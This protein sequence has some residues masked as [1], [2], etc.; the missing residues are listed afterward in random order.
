M[1]VFEELNERHLGTCISL[2]NILE[3][4]SQRVHC[5]SSDLLASDDTIWNSSHLIARL[6][7]Q[8]QWF[9]PELT[10]SESVNIIGKNMYNNLIKKMI[11][12]HINGIVYINNSVNTRYCYGLSEEEL[13]KLDMLRAAKSN[14]KRDVL[15]ISKTSVLAA[16]TQHKIANHECPLDPYNF[17]GF[18][19]LRRKNI[20]GY[21]LPCKSSESPKW[22][23]ESLPSAIVKLVS[24]QVAKGRMNESKDIIE[25]FR[26][27][28]CRGIDL[29]DYLS[30]EHEL[31]LRTILFSM[32]MSDKNCS[33]YTKEYEQPIY[34]HRELASEYPNDSPLSAY[35]LYKKVV[36]GDFTAEYDSTRWYI[37]N[38]ASLAVSSTRRNRKSIEEIVRMIITVHNKPYLLNSI[39]KS[40]ENNNTRIII[41]MLLNVLTMPLGM[42]LLLSVEFQDGYLTEG[43]S[44]RQS[45]LHTRRMMILK[46][47]MPVV[48]HTLARFFAKHGMLKLTAKSTIDLLRVAA[49]ACASTQRRSTNLHNDELEQSE[50][51]YR[52]ITECIMETKVV[53][54]ITVDGKSYQPSIV[55]YYCTE[56]CNDLEERFSSIEAPSC[57]KASITVLEA[58]YSD[59]SAIN[60]NGE[61]HAKS[62]IRVLRLVMH[63]YRKIFKLDV[64]DKDFRYVS[65]L[66]VSPYID[67]SI[68]LFSMKE[69]RQFSEFIEFRPIRDKLRKLDKMEKLYEDILAGCSARLR[70]HLKVL[71]QAY[72][73]I[74]KST[75]ISKANKAKMQNYLEDSI[76]DLVLSISDPAKGSV[77]L[78]DR[79]LVVELPGDNSFAELVS[80]TVRVARLFSDG[81]Y[82]LQQKWIAQMMDPYILLIM[83]QDI[84]HNDHLKQVKQKLEKKEIL[85][86]AL[87]EHSMLKIIY[88]VQKAALYNHVK[89]ANRLIKYGSKSFK[90]HAMFN[91]WQLAAFRSSLLLA[92]NK[93]SREDIKNIALPSFGDEANPFVKAKYSEAE[94]SRS[95]YLALLDLH[96]NPTR[97]AKAFQRLLRRTSNPISVL[98]NLFAAKLCNAERV[99][100]DETRRSAYEAALRWWQNS[101]SHMKDQIAYSSVAVRNTLIAMD[102]AELDSEFDEYWLEIDD[103][104]QKHPEI[105]LIKLDNLKRRGLKSQYN[106]YKSALGE[107]YSNELPVEETHHAQLSIATEVT[108]PQTLRT[109]LNNWYAIKSLQ[110]EDLSRILGDSG[111][112][113]LTEHIVNIH[114]KSCSELLT[115]ISAV[116]DLTDENKYNDLIVSYTKMQVQLYDWHVDEQARGGKPG[117]GNTG[118]RSGVGERDWII[119]VSNR[120]LCVCEALRFSSGEWGSVHSHIEKLASKYN[121]QGA[122]NGLLLVYAESNSAFVKIA[123]CYIK[124]IRE[125]R[126]EEWDCTKIS[127]ITSQHSCGQKM[128]V[129]TSL[130]E[131]KCASLEKMTLSHIIVDIS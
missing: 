84:I 8:S 90:T 124:K 75:K 35:I 65:E 103:T 4:I 80:D 11:V 67:F 64:P 39:I 87:K 32:L 20:D 47:A 92:Y 99:E 3:G 70:N 69:H 104:L 24:Y 130:L 108:F 34:W 114:L 82:E 56:I 74:R 45:R 31:H 43:Y 48:S 97:A 119:R 127:D 28:Y 129:Y 76:S 17:D 55:G 113:E 42:Y 44:E 41:Y 15:W 46:E 123:Q 78:F 16:I 61:K 98:A 91:D 122:R 131:K 115:R 30:K 53:A 36:G 52:I 117:S 5:K 60:I 86:T 2:G 88:I 57:L 62:I 107:K 93:N 106:N 71:L 26:V 9:E 105:A 10:E 102:S 68:P 38:A 73:Q 51:V 126:Y 109:H 12:R 63:M 89:I 7:R 14:G 96:D 116:K 59:Q 112:K 25:F 83:S 85:N 37:R 81:G 6:I 27:A 101:T 66:E 128:L 33:D 22:Y 72:M 13:D 95:F 40:I 94:E 21:E 125:Y 58:L 18:P 110:P 29:I 79:S 1:K 19:P 49:L 121:P 118:S 77:D 100:E 50:A 54:L 111:G 23:V 120:D